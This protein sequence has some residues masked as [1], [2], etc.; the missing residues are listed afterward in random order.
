M[1]ARGLIPSPPSLPTQSCL[2]QL[3]AL[4]GAEVAVGRPPFAFLGLARA[5][6]SDWL[7]AV[8]GFLARDGRTLTQAQRA[9]VAAVLSDCPLPLMARL[10]YIVARNWKSGDEPVVQRGNKARYRGGGG[11]S[12]SAVGV[13]GER[14]CM[15]DT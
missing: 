11:G 12:M 8:D 13:W 4:S 14:L 6:A 7:A 15:Q 3:R 1:A 5:P 10:T 9:E 2:E